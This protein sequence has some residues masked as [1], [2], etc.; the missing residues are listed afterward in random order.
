MPT[1][2]EGKKG[3]Q[4]HK[5]LWWILGII[6]VVALISGGLIYAYSGSDDD[7]SA[8]S[9]SSVKTVNKP[10]TKS[11]RKTAKSSSTS[12]SSSES[13]TADDFVGL[14]FQI[15]P[16]LF[17]GEDV[18]D[19]MEAG[20]AQPSLVHDGSQLGYFRSNTEV[21]ITG[22][23]GYM[24]AHSAEYRVVDGVLEMGTW[25]IPIK[26]SD[27]AIQTTRWESEDSDDSHITWKIEAL[28]DAQSTVEAHVNPNESSSASNSELVDQHNLT[29]AQME[30][31]VR[32]YI[33]S[34]SQVYV[35]NAYSFTQQ[36]V[37]GYAQISSYY[38]DSNTDKSS[39]AGVY[40]VDEHGYL[41][42]KIEPD[43]GSWRVVS[44]HYE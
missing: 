6:L 29:S 14:G 18:T 10:T 9:S 25:N 30:H 12:S 17:N 1:R 44:K 33:E 19:A 40:R 22:I 8:A 36:F 38:N 42:E 35:A 27:G 37:D 16:V 4:G 5:R 11:S 20:K 28:S 31:W 26:V 7:S 13:T 2:M 43:S 15:T 3:R 21:R 34:I 41:Q 23:A 39:L 24:F 32:A